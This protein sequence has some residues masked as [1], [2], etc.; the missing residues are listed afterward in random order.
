MPEWV[1][2]GSGN[3]RI[4]VKVISRIEGRPRVK[5]FPC[6][7]ADKVDQRI[8]SRPDSLAVVFTVV[9]GIEKWIGVLS[10]KG[11]EQHIVK[12]G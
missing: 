11:P 8:L 7:M 3:V 12:Y 4:L 10:F 2:L 6:A 9:L 5:S 1:E